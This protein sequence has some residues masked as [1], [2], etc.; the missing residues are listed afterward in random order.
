MFYFVFKRK[1]KK[2]LRWKADLLG[3]DL[4]LHFKSVKVGSAIHMKQFSA[5]NY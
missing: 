3:R 2:N 5:L 1:R 4:H